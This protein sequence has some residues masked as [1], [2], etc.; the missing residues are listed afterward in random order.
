MARDR[1]QQGFEM[2]ALN[3][4]A[5]SISL[6]LFALLGAP[7]FA[8]AS[9]V[10]LDINTFETIAAGHATER[11]CRQLNLDDREEL[12]THAAYAETA[13]A[14]SNGSGQVM[15]ARKRA[16][17]AAS[18][19]SGARDRVMAG[20]NAGRRFEQR[21]VNQR[22]AQAR[23]QRRKQKRKTRQARRQATLAPVRLTR[24]QQAEARRAETRAPRGSMARF[25]S[26][27]RA[28]YL[29]RRCNHLSY[30]QAL[31]FWKLIA[32]QHGR[33]VRR[34]GAGAVVR[35]ERQAKSS[36]RRARCGA[37][38]KQQVIAGLRG[39]RRDR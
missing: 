1:A 13:A 4:S 29:Q 25:K 20:L 11:K 28:Y 27:T 15:A 34:H 32:A 30:K 6:V 14:R 9:P 24:R 18:C 3:T 33:M 37:R 21:F 12:A 22:N 39:I 16:K 8:S 35:A 23:A 19:G 5:I 10:G 17:G 31:R 36:A 7:H 38:T 2:K 26:Q